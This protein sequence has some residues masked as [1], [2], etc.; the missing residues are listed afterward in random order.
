MKCLPIPNLGYGSFSKFIHENAAK[1]RIPISGGLELTFRCNLKCVHCYASSG[2][3]N[4]S[5]E[6]SFQEICKI[7]DEIANEGCLWLLITGGEPLTR[8]DF[9]DI[10][11]YAKKKGFIITLFTN[12]TLINEDVIRCFQKWRP[13]NIEVT[14]YGAKQKTYETISGIMGSYNQCI[15]GIDL[16]LNAGLPLTLKSIIMSLNKHEIEELRQFSDSHGM[17]FLFD[18]ILNLGLNNS[19][20]PKN[21]RLT[22]EE[23]VELD[24]SDK[25]RF[26]SWKEYLDDFGGQ[27][28]SDN[29]YLCGAG[30]TSFFINP[31][32]ELQMCVLSRFPSYNLRKGNFSKGWHSFIREI[33]KKKVQNNFRCK[34]CNLLSFCGQCPGWS[35]LEYGNSDTPV[36]YLCSIAHLRAA[37]I[38]RS[39]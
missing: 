25:E 2:I 38:H 4:D 24:I 5:E 14:L 21:Y 10:Y 23:V 27:P 36:D 20:H 39:Y 34:K 33:R 6:Y 16:L 18:P 30:E 29:L 8:N 37:A 13:F 35:Q 28:L 32:G 19:E 17:P 1:E 31:Y 15:R 12:G 9:L 3:K 7:L 22:P 26:Q 11:V